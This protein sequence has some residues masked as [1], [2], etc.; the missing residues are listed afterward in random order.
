MIKNLKN[1]TA[2]NRLTSHVSKDNILN[3][4]L[5]DLIYYCKCLDY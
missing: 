5:F 1:K 2:C 3:V 4:L